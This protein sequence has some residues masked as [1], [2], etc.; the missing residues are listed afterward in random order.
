MIL[1]HWLNATM[2]YAVY[3]HL[4]SSLEHPMFRLNEVLLT[5]YLFALLTKWIV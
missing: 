3:L 5:A 2:R 4:E 1:S